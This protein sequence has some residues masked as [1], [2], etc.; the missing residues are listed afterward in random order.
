MLEIRF[1]LP[2]CESLEIVCFPSLGCVHIFLCHRGESVI[3][4]ITYKILRIL[5]VIIDRKA[6]IIDNITYESVDTGR[7]YLVTEIFDK[8][9]SVR[10]K[11]G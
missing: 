7:E 11:A 2:K 6:F 1:D 4:N 3:L 8:P 9:S 10:H 5:G